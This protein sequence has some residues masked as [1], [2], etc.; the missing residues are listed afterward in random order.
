VLDGGKIVEEGTHLELVRR[1]GRYAS[2]F[3]LQSGAA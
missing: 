3:N 1:R 2:F